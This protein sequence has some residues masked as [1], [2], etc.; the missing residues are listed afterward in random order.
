MLAMAKSD[1]ANDADQGSAKLTAF[2]QKFIAE[3]LISFN[4]T[5]AYRRARGGKCSY[6]TA[7]VE[8]H[9][10]LR[11]PKIAAEVRAAVRAIAKVAKVKAKRIVEGLAKVALADPLDLFD[12]DQN[13]N[14]RTRTMREVPYRMRLA[15]ASVKTQVLSRKL[16]PQTVNGE[17]LMIE[18]SV[19]SREVKFN[20]RVAAQDKLLKMLGEY[21]AHNRQRQKPQTQAEIDA[22]KE[23]LR[24]RGVNLDVINARSSSN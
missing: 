2:Q 3:Y 17:V 19:V 24:A 10:T 5:Q 15:I 18:E 14:E 9:R 12:Y 8:S 1:T 16:V 21:E 7:M 4:A 20:D 13:G 6:A 22:L 11:I 23:R